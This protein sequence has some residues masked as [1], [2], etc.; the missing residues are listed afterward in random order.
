[1]SLRLITYVSAVVKSS[2]PRPAH[3][4]V[5]RPSYVFPDPLPVRSIGQAGYVNA[6]G[7]TIQVRTFFEASRHRYGSPRILRDLDDAGERVS[8]KRVVRLMQED[9]LK[10]RVRKR[11]KHTTVSDHDQPIAENLLKQTFDAERPNQRW[12]G[13][14]TEFVIGTSCKLYLA[15][16]LMVIS[17]VTNVLAQLIVRKFEK[18]RR[19]A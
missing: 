2:L 12:A 6:G 16:I 8:S 4:F 14:T 7:A 3:F 1:M 10:A 19:A 15:A 18:Q 11:Y 9:G 17:L 5:T 13:D